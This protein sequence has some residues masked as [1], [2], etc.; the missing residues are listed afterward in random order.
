[1]IPIDELIEIWVRVHN[2]C[3]AKYAKIAR[4]AGADLSCAA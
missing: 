1:M 4:D 2:E 3:R